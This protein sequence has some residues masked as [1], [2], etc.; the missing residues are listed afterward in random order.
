M[1]LLMPPL[2]HVT[3]AFAA[4]ALSRSVYQVHRKAHGLA[5]WRIVFAAMTLNRLEM[6][7]R[8]GGNQAASYWRNGPI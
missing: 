4:A 6:P 1:A 7:Q 8:I 2:I 3:R 5:R